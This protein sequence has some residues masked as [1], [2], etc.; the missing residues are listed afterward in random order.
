MAEHV[1]SGVRD[2]SALLREKYALEKCC[3]ICLKIVPSHQRKQHKQAA[4]H[5]FLVSSL[6]SEIY[7]FPCIECE[8]RFSAKGELFL[9]ALGDCGNLPRSNE[10]HTFSPVCCYLCR[11]PFMR[12]E[13][14]DIHCAT[15]KEHHCRRQMVLEVA[16]REAMVSEL[17]D[18]NNVPVVSSGSTV[19]SVQE[20]AKT[21][22][23]TKRE[24]SAT[25]DTADTA[26]P[27]D[28][29]NVCNKEEHLKLEEEVLS[30]E[31]NFITRK[32]VEFFYFG[33]NNSSE[34]LNETFCSESSEVISVTPSLRSP[35][36]VVQDPK[37]NLLYNEPEQSNEKSLSG[38]NDVLPANNKGSHGVTLRGVKGTENALHE[39]MRDISSINDSCPSELSIMAEIDEKLDFNQAMKEPTFSE[40]SEF[41]N[42]TKGDP[43][44]Y[45]PSSTIA[46]S[47][48]KEELVPKVLSIPTN[49]NVAVEISESYC[50]ICSVKVPRGNMPG[51]VRGKNHRKINEKLLAESKKRQKKDN[52]L[53]KIVDC[54]Q[55][56]GSKALLQSKST[57]SELI[58]EPKKLISEDAIKIGDSSTA[59]L[60][61]EFEGGVVSDGKD[62]NDYQVE[63]EICGVVIQ[64]LNNNLD[65]SFEMHVQN[66]PQHALAISVPVERDAKQMAELTQK[67]SALKR[68]TR[69]EVGPKICVAKGD[70]PKYCT[71]K[72][73]NVNKKKAETARPMA[74]SRSKSELIASS[75]LTKKVN[76]NLLNFFCKICEKNMIQGNKKT[77]EESKLHKANMSLDFFCEICSE[78]MTR[79]DMLRHELSTEHK[80]N[81]SGEFFC[82]IC[83]RLMMVANK[84]SHL[85]GKQHEKK[86]LLDFFCEICS[87][88]MTLG[89]KESHASSPRHKENVSVEF[90]CHVCDKVMMVANKKSHIEG[91]QHKSKAS[92]SFF[93]EICAEHMTLGEKENH[94]VSPRH[95]ENASAEFVCHVCDKVMMVA[96]R[97]GHLEGKLHKAKASST[98]FC[99]IC[100]KTMNNG[101]KSSHLLGKQHRQILDGL[102]T[103]I[104]L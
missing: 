80:E 71:V 18:L 92:S 2:S 58:T 3:L 91:R 23:F 12:Q 43:K 74:K 29:T 95:R 75:Q 6:K 51:H 97:K 25:E 101:S 86:A 36:S 57:S 60:Q 61:A 40:L 102:Q 9:H 47:V 79:G 13:D 16:L 10:G 98:F 33:Q 44:E 24:I 78:H 77:H 67:S 28:S 63:C 66:D 96:N 83:D 53:D 19:S 89:E 49:P 72:E 99:E 54:D 56:N 34:V 64:I 5:K 31:R 90:V 59:S 104:L 14:L 20:C 62:L 21:S 52:S 38:S 46:V 15:S 50:Y 73:C 93:C 84:E 65:L 37:T 103:L 48:M 68:V 22:H 94:V 76:P 39:T 70:G 17:L 88:H 85:E 82:Q 45:V 11:L 42:A 30:K 26:R 100:N 55:I 69:K 7:P 41:K 32:S 81:V 87:E 35:V 8:M 4:A 27:K 1:P